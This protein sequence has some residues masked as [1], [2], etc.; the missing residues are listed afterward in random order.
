MTETKLRLS[1][2][3]VSAKVRSVTP[4][5]GGLTA[6]TGAQFEIRIDGTRVHD[7]RTSQWRGGAVPQ[8]QACAQHGRGQRLAKRRRYRGGSQVRLIEMGWRGS[9]RSGLDR[10]TDRAGCAGS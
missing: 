3:R 10:A 5:G 7:R 4:L 6:M 8:E 1:K 2:S 9:S